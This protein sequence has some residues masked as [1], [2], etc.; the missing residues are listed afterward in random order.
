MTLQA[1]RGKLEAVT[2]DA[3][4][5]GGVASIAFDNTME[6]PT[7]TPHA[8]I[9]LSFGPMSSPSMGCSPDHVR[10]TVSVTIATARG[11]GSVAG[12]EAGLAV[13]C[14]WGNL[15]TDYSEALRLRTFDQQGPVTIAPGDRP[16]H[17]HS[18]S[19]SFTAATRR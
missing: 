16:V 15:N 12:E 4:I 13:I 9:S 3:L 7:A 19:C 8:S 11:K 1:T 2:R 10:G 14:A 17:V 6:T 18:V 5:A